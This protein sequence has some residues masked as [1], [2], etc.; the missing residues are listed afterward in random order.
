VGF[1]EGLALGGLL[2]RRFWVDCGERGNT[3]LG[4]VDSVSISFDY[5][6][7]VKSISGSSATAMESS[8]GIRVTRFF[9]IENFPTE[10]L[11]VLCGW[12]LS[13]FCTS[14]GILARHRCAADGDD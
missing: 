7:S 1:H 3:V 6:W 12:Q 5:T 14:D 4:R 9:G 13:L 8:I 2:L 10:K 11:V